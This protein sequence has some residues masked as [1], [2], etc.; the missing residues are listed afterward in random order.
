VLKRMTVADGD[1]RAHQSPVDYVFINDSCYFDIDLRPP[2]QSNH[3]L[4]WNKPISLRNEDEI[5]ALLFF[6][7]HP[8]T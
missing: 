4:S 1:R 2:C 6:G 3:A 7:Q 5:F 8:S